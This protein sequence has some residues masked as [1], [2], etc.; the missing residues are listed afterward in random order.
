MR[1]REKR[2]II[3][4]R[5]QP[6]EE[7]EVVAMAEEEEEEVAVEDAP[8]GDETEGGDEMEAE[9]PRRP[10]EL[11]GNIG[12]RRVPAGV[13]PPA[14]ER[15]VVG[16]VAGRGQQH[17]FLRKSD[18][19]CECLISLGLEFIDMA[20]IDLKLLKD[21]AWLFFLEDTLLG[22][23]ESTL[24][25]GFLPR[26]R[27]QP[28][29]RSR[30][31][32]LALRHRYIAMVILP[33]NSGAVMSTLPDDCKFSGGGN[34]IMLHEKLFD[35]SSNLSVPEKADTRRNWTQTF[36]NSPS[37]REFASVTPQISDL[38][39][40][41]AEG[42]GGLP[43]GCKEGGNRLW[44]EDFTAGSLLLAIAVGKMSRRVTRDDG[45]P[46]SEDS[47]PELTEAVER[48]RRSNVG[49]TS[50]RADP[51]D[52]YV[53]RMVVDNDKNDMGYLYEAM[54]RAKMELRQS[55]PKGYKKWWKI[56]DHRW[57]NTLHH[58]LHPDGILDGHEPRDP[59]FKLLAKRPR[60]SSSKGK[61][62]ETAEDT[63]E[64]FEPAR[65]SESDSRPITQNGEATSI[66]K[67]NCIRDI[68][69]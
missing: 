56:I 15:V 7:E 44:R 64:Q 19:R 62:P 2:G 4:G 47:D 22:F 39:G 48:E 55:L 9:A 57:E 45:E 58:D 49:T 28:L 5:R 3:Q 13:Q 14:V 35:I 51:M 37:N 69:D 34:N 68:Y 8:E 29:P 30:L 27:P 50:Q 32:C 20:L 17:V 11:D 26:P 10:R 60:E 36:A 33:P 46:N 40:F 66:I 18:I 31:F 12:C 42:G 16:L 43:Q 41:A 23:N 59:K 52:S 6:E 53:L 1:T 63:E 61:Q 54:D 24:G 21:R 38:R 67:E 65:Y 25:L